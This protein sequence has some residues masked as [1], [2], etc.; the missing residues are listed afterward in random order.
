MSTDLA[1]LSAT[2]ALARFR[3]RSLSPVEVTEALIARAAEVEPTVNALCI[4][5]FDEA[6][7]AGPRG[8]GAVP[9]QG[10][11]A[12]AAG[13]RS[14]SAIKDEMPIK[15]QRWTMGSLLLR[16]PG[17]PRRPTRSASG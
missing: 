6:I 14:A 17:A 13:G 12:A 8:R 15:G 11:G 7:D 3:D 1:Y 5:Y 16:G 9:G 2:E 10:H 4:T